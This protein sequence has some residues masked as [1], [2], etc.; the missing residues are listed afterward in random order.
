MNL[1][2]TILLVDL[3]T[4]ELRI[5]RSENLPVL[6]EVA[7]SILRLAQDPDAPARAYELAIERDPAL[8]GK[9]LR[10]SSSAMYGVGDVPNLG[11]AIAVLGMTVLKSLVVTLSYQQTLEKIPGCEEFDGVQCWRHSLATAYACRILAKL[12]MPQRA[13]ELYMA[14]LL[15][16][17]GLLA[18]DKFC[19][20]MLGQSIRKAFD[21][22]TPLHIAESATYGYDHAAVG[23]L[24]ADRWG[25]GKIARAAIRHHLD[26]FEKREDAEAAC[27]LSAANRIAFE[28]A[29]P[30][31]SPLPDEGFDD[32]VMDYIAIPPEQYTPICDVVGAE[33]ASTLR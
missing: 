5:A 32:R 24:L 10:V 33:V 22:G 1:R 4:L 27:I 20:S 9:V 25:L 31:N 16:D 23:A 26:P 17:V 29:C 3:R 8:A 11:R 14:G 7:L 6:N 15:H 28:C 30:N 12:R 18:M 13:E 2:P 19:P 21:D